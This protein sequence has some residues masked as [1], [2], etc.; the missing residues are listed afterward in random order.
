MNKNPFFYIQICVSFV[1]NTVKN[2]GVLEEK[3]ILNLNKAKGLKRGSNLAIL[4]LLNVSFFIYNHTINLNYTSLYCE[5]CKTQNKDQ[6]YLVFYD[7]K[8]KQG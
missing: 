4:Y 8:I 6:V 1:K 5:I 7:F 2:A 3:A